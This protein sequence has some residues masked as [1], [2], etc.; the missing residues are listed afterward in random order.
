MT[1]RNVD[2]VKHAVV[3]DTIYRP[4]YADKPLAL[5]PGTY[6]FDVTDKDLRILA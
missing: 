1:A 2:R 4:P 3:E 6:R 5:R